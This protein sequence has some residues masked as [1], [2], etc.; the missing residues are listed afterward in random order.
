MSD[1]DHVEVDEEPE[2]EEHGLS[3]RDLLLG[4]GMLMAGA[5]VLR[6]R[7]RRALRY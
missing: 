4:G 6:S 1:Q 5:G 2:E 7:A 3:R